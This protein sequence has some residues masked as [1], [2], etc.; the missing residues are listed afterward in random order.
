MKII[1]TDDQGQH[2][3]KILVHGEAGT[4]KTRLC[5]TTGVPDETVIISAEGGLLSLRD[6]S[7]TAVECSSKEDVI[8]AY[9]WL[10]ESDEARGIQWVC[11][12]SISEIAE[13]VLAHERGQ[14]KDPRRA[15]GELALVMDKLI[16]SFRDL[17]RHVYM[18]CKTERIQSEAGLIWSPS[19]P[20][21]K[22]GQSLP[23]LFDE[24]FCLRCHKDSES[25]EIKRWLQC[26][27]D[28]TYA[29]K[30]RSGSLE[31][32]EAP[33]LEHIHAKILGENNG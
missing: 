14:T 3:L 29:A 9:R 6:T 32:Y 26:Q 31:M 4:G 18:T 25:G 1:K 15:Y 19:M 7:L 33:S 13:Q 16:K 12:D 11:I 5:A 17:D 20:G 2:W 10:C 27:A 22:T 24:L 23:F 30:D 8:D 21:N 28:G